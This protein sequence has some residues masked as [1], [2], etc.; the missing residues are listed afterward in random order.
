MPRNTYQTKSI[1]KHGL[2]FKYPKT[3][4]C[5]LKYVTNLVGDR[6]RGCQTIIR[7]SVLVVVSQTRVVEPFIN[8]KKNT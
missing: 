1:P 2:S 3:G 7:S 8:K 5:M 6:L 4:R